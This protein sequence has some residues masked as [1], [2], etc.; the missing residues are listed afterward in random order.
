MAVPE[1]SG[2]W[3]YIRSAVLVFVGNVGVPSVFQH[4]V[5]HAMDAY[6]NAVGSSPTSTWDT[7][8]RNDSCVP[9]DYSNTSI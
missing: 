6:N 8:I 5:G 1:T 4:E 3:A 7:A 2:S 9:D